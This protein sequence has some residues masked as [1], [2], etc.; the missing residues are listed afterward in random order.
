MPLN[1]LIT[2]EVLSWVITRCGRTEMKSPVRSGRLGPSAKWACAIFSTTVCGIKPVPDVYEERLYDFPR[3]LLVGFA[4]RCT[5]FFV[6]TSV[7]MSAMSFEIE[8]T[9][10]RF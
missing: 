9:F 10:S 4:L 7:S 1:L 6:L 5:D 3:L 8:P 2:A